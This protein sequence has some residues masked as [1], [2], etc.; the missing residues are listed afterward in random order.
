MSQVLLVVDDLQDWSPYFPSER[1]IG[2]DEYL[3]FDSSAKQR[4]R[5]INLCK[6][7]SYL[8][9]GYYCSLL[10]EAKQH[11]VIPS[12]RVLNDMDNPSLYQLD[13]GRVSGVITKSLKN[14]PTDQ[15]ITAKSFFGQVSEEWLKPIARALF[16]R[17]PCPILAFT[18][19]HTAKRWAILDIHVVSAHGLDDAE[20]T[21]FAEALDQF[22]KKVWREVKPKKVARYDLAMLVNHEET[23][24]PSNKAAL[25]KFIAAGKSL[26]IDVETIGPDDFGRLS[27]FDGLFIRETTSIDHHTYK[28]CQKSRK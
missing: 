25:N 9:Q 27:E 3:A 20:E 2:F 12:V 17:F 19:R 28:V 24:P 15:D 6:S 23:L 4:V 26:G 13:L 16:E 21:A 8:K 1:V 18:L 11:K 5:V 10:A 22:C 14:V 7:Y